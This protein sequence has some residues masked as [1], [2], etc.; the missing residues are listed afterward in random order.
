M[1]IH[2]EFFGR[3]REQ[4]VLSQAFRSSRSEF[5]PVYGRRRVGKSTLI[6]EFL[7][8]HTGIY[9]VGKRAPEP[10]QIHEFLQCAASALK[11][12]LLESFPATDWKSA[13][14]AVVN[15][16]K[17][18]EKLIIV[19]DEFQWT[20][21]Y[22]TG[23]PSILQELW[24]RDWRKRGNVFLILC[25][26]YIGFMEREVLGH[27]SPLFGRRTSQMLVQPFGYHE[28]AEFHPHYSLEERVKSYFVCG[29]IPLYLKQFHQD[30]SVEQNIADNLLTE[31]SPLFSEPDFLLREEFREVEKYYAILLAVAT[32][33]TTTHAVSQLTGVGERSLH[34]Y[35][36]TL[37]DLGYLTRRYPLTGERPAARHVRF[38][39][40]DP[41]LRFWFRFV[42]PN[43]SYILQRG[44]QRAFQEI[45]RPELDSYFGSCFERLCR[46]ALPRLYEREKLTAAFEVGEYWDKTTQIDVVGLREDRWTDLGECKWGAVKSVKEL[47]AEVSD[48]VVNFPNRRDA[49][50]RRRVFTRTP[51]APSRRRDSSITWHSLRDL[52]E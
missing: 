17:G 38:A 15:R 49:T 36:E 25:G 24:D 31:F 29:G 40:E 1:P 50:I 37:T 12:P 22:S 3:K 13:L 41:L 8:K 47:E 11:E 27:K 21:E 28:A 26:S 19:L 51:V 2:E 48:K 39:L 44:P 42:Y 16:W 52:Y 10:L 33:N 46:E 35:I 4:D 43:T 32:G 23:L 9:H 6:L 45:I 14:T 18:K 30:R 34:Y 20:V 5:I 7:A